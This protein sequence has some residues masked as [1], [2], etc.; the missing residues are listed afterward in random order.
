MAGLVSPKIS[1]QESPAFS[2]QLGFWVCCLWVTFVGH[3]FATLVLSDF[4]MT[5]VLSWAAGVFV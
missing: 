4:S 3:R 1:C 5:I 2:H